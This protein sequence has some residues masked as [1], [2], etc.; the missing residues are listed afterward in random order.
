[1]KNSRIGVREGYVTIQRYGDQL[2]LQGLPVMGRSEQ[3]EL[4]NRKVLISRK[5]AGWFQRLCYDNANTSFKIKVRIVATYKGHLAY[6]VPVVR[7]KEEALV[8][9]DMIKPSSAESAP[10]P[11]HTVMSD[12]AFDYAKKAHEAVAA[13]NNLIVLE[14]NLEGERV[15]TTVVDKAS[16]QKY[17]VS[18]GFI[19]SKLKNKI[20][21]GELDWQ[22]QVDL[23]VRTRP[24]NS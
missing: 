24:L 4:I 5:A 13:K 8:E 14:H 17:V 1:M 16:G 20:E 22:K 9:W 2:V 6:A 21:S 7:S 11:G 12:D 18:G 15:R 23:F 10:A 3:G 19:I